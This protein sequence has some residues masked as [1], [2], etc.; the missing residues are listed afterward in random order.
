M[1]RK[2]A[3]CQKGRRLGKYRA[4]IDLVESINQDLGKD[5]CAYSEQELKDEL[6]K[7]GGISYYVEHRDG[8]VPS[9]IGITSS[10]DRGLVRLRFGILY[11]HLR[12]R[13]L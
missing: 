9:H 2:S 6:K 13:K 10:K 4:A 11:G 3:L 12:G 1:N 8:D 5:I 7:Q